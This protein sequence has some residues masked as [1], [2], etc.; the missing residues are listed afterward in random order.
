MSVSDGKVQATAE[1]KQ[2]NSFHAVSD[3]REI[4]VLHSSGPR[5]EENNH[6]RG[7]RDI[8][9]SKDDE[10]MGHQAGLALMQKALQAERDM[11]KCL[12]PFVSVVHVASALA[13]KQA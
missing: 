3:V 9:V 7:K 6:N 12:K 4:V 2:I 8:I 11:L 5:D 1:P 13:L 10:N